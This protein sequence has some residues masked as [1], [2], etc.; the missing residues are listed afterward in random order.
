MAN[1]KQSRGEVWAALIGG[2]TLL[3]AVYA[4]NATTKASYWHEPFLVGLGA[5]GLLISM[6]PVVH[7][8]ARYVHPLGFAIPDVQDRQQKRATKQARK[9]QAEKALSRLVNIAGYYEN[10]VS[11]HIEHRQLSSHMFDFRMQLKGLPASLRF[12]TNLEGLSVTTD[13]L[14]AAVVEEEAA[15]QEALQVLLEDQSA[16]WQD[17]SDEDVERMKALLDVI[18]VTKDAAAA[19]LS[20]RRLG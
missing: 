3:A 11:I 12:D 4:A 8:F 17:A 19:E 13:R 6:Y 7:W 16:H 15:A 2:P 5:L 9:Q 1:R 20:R 10:I 18:R 14:L